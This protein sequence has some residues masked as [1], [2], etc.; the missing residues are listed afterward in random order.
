MLAS[1]MNPQVAEFDDAPAVVENQVIGWLVELLDSRRDAWPAR[2]GGSMANFVGLAVA[3]N[4]RG[5]FDI[6][7]ERRACRTETHGI[8]VERNHSSV[9]KAVELWGS[10][11]TPCARFPSPPT[12]RS[13]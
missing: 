6:R 5:G 10:V 7:R 1:G 11:T 8:R 3:R 13:T 12:T 2:S 9:R 4:A